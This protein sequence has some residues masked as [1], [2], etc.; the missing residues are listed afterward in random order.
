MKIEVLKPED[1]EA[2]KNLIDEC[3]GTSNDLEQYKKYQENQT[4]T[5]FVV[6]DGDKIAGSATQYSID[7]FTFR[8]QPCL[9]LFN[10]AVSVD[11]R[12]KKI[13]QKLLDYIIENA[14]AEG[15]NS[16]SLTCLDDAYAAHKLYESMG[17]KKA[18]SLKYDLYL[19][20]K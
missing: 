19:T 17:F 7:L 13:G 5:I 8:F 20:H 3:F 10:I 9:M 15:Y 4:Y 6:K 2:Y 18:G 12:R 1:L 11:Y 16:I 14:K